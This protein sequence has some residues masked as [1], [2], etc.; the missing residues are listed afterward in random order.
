MTHR[1]FPAGLLAL[2]LAGCQAAENLGN[3]ISSAF[4]SSGDEE[5]AATAANASLPAAASYSVIDGDTLSLG[6]A[7]IRLFGIDAPEADQFCEVEQASVPCGAIARE[8]LVGFVAGATVRCDQQD[9]DRYGREVSRCYADGYD[10]SAGLARTGLAVAYRQ[11]SSLYV[12]EEEQARSFGR[13]M[14]KGTFEMPW[15]WRS[16]RR[17]Q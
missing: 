7:R 3:T 11:Y 5:A 2:T 12:A 14:W 4:D 8:A 15:D 13:G 10:L 6:D 9:T 17:Q 16:K 1:M